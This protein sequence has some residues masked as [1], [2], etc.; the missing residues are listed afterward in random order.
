MSRKI[1]Q[2]ERKASKNLLRMGASYGGDFLWN[3]KIPERRSLAQRT[4]L[5]SRVRK[6]HKASSKV[7]DAPVEAPK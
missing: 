6:N 5:I 7:M 2:K 3:V 1:A 4:R